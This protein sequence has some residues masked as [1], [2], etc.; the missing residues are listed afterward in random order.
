MPGIWLRFL[1]SFIFVFGMSP[2]RTDLSF[3][4]MRPLTNGQMM[5]ATLK[6]AAISTCF[7][8]FGFGGLVRHAF[9]GRFP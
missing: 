9:A 3:L 8:G 1:C 4:M 6:A 2:A 5:M 7:R